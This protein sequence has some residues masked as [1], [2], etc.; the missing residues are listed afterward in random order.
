MVLLVRVVRKVLQEQLEQQAP[1]VSLDILVRLVPAG[2]QVALDKVGSRDL[3]EHRVLKDYRV[4][5][6]H[7]VSQV[8]L[9]KLDKLD[10]QVSVVR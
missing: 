3:K 4:V 7:R 1:K 5:L 10:K 9:V 2:R 6:D 8:P